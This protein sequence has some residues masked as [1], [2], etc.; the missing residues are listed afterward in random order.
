MLAPL[1]IYLHR[2]TRRALALALAPALLLLAVE[3]AV[4]HFAGKEA[5]G[6]AQWLPVGYGALGAVLVAWA[7]LP[8]TSR[9]AFGVGCRV[10]GAVGA[11]VGLLG[12]G[13]HLWA[14]GAELGGEY[15][16][17]ALQGALASAPPLFAPAAFIGVGLALWVVGSPRVLIRLR[18]V[19]Q[20]PA[21]EVVPLRK[22]GSGPS[23][24]QGA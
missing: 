10:L 1:I 16:W 20:R 2:H 12:L 23:S 22:G 9:Q 11:L 21:G 6:P 3:A 14:L 13:L 7:A 5:E 18:P 15:S 19:E 8:R 24:A 17:P 4:A